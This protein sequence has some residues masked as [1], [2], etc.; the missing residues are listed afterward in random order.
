MF[1]HFQYENPPFNVLASSLKLKYNV[2]SSSIGLINTIIIGHL[3]VS[4]FG[5]TCNARSC[6]LLCLRM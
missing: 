6:S 4:A 3:Q 1:N 5:E 2:G